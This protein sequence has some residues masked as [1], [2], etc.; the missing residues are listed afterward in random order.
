M[1]ICA[2]IGLVSWRAF[3]G[4]DRA[5]ISLPV[6]EIET[7]ARANPLPA[8]NGGQGGLILGPPGAGDTGEDVEDMLAFNGDYA[9]IT[10]LTEEN[11]DAREYDLADIKITIAGESAHEPI[12]ASLTRPRERPTPILDAPGNMLRQTKFGFAPTINKSGEQAFHKYRHRYT[13]KSNQPEVAL[14]VGGLGLDKALTERAIDELPPSVTLSFAPY[15]TE[16]EFWTRKAREAGHEIVLELPMEGYG[17]SAKALGS[18]G[19][20]TTRSDRENLERLDWL[21]SRFT[22][23][24]GATNYNGAKL[25]ASSPNIDPIIGQLRESGV[26]YFDDTGAIPNSA[27]TRRIERILPPA[28]TAAEKDKMRFALKSLEEEARANGAVLAKTYLYAN[29]LEE[30][31]AW[32]DTLENRGI[33]SAPASAMLPSRPV[34]R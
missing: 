30:I 32:V 24:V 7:M 6:N 27:T 16:L 17:E 28:R 22:T 9:P 20:L 10:P 11:I 12:A 25:S 34:N 19:L 3:S 31:T 15:A 33:V 23:Y 1:G 26:A 8:G 2:I 13:N 4:D 21:M 29:S 18:A 14:I 5:R